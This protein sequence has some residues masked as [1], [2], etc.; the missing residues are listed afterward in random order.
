MLSGPRRLYSFHEGGANSIIYICVLY[1]HKRRTDNWKSFEVRTK[2]DLQ[3]NDIIDYITFG[4]ICTRVWLLCQ[5][6]TTLFML[7]LCSRVRAS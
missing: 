2:H 5:K 1:G 7:I 6:Y 3:V 4:V